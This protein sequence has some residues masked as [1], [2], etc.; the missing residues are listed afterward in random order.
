MVPAMDGLLDFWIGR[1]RVVG[2]DG[3]PAGEN[4]IE[5]F[6]GAVVE[7]WRGAGGDEGVSLFFLADVWTQVWV[8]PGCRKEKRH[9]PEWTDGVRFVGT[10][11]VGARQLADRTTLTPLPDRRVRQV[12]EQERDGVWVA[13]FDAIYERVD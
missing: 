6:G 13:S 1:W 3:T 4:E 2:H 7:R 12:I 11:F 5:S 9:D 10:A 8:Q